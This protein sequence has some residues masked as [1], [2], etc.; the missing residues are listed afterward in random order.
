MPDG[1]SRQ[2]FERSSPGDLASSLVVKSEK[3]GENSVLAQAVSAI[4]QGQPAGK[5][6][7]TL[8]MA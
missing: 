8:L 4:W 7:I 3:Q 2:T 5:G 6:R 1:G